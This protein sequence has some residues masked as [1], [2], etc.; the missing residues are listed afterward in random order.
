MEALG[1]RF[2]GGLA[3]WV[4]DPVLPQLQLRSQLQLRFD[5]CHRNSI[6]HRV[7]IKEKRKKKVCVLVIEGEEYLRKLKILKGRG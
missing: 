1:C 5:P 7:S 3:Q 2:D 4:K 6:C